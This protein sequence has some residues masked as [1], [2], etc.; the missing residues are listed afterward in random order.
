[1]WSPFHVPGNEAVFEHWSCFDK[2]CFTNLLENYE[3]TYT[4]IQYYPQI[5]L[6]PF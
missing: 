2:S 5:C 6:L 1:M 3:I 4:C